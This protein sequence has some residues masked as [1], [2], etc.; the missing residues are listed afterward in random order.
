MRVLVVAP[1]SDFSVA[2]VERGYTKAL[3]ALGCDVATYNLNDRLVYFANC[4]F[5]GRNLEGSEIVL[6]AAWG[7]HGKLYEWWPDLLIVIS[8]FY[9][10]PFT[11]ELLKTRP[12]RTVIVFTESPYEDD[13]QLNLVSEAD[14]DIVILNDPTNRDRFDA[15]HDDVHYFPHAYDPDIHH[16][17]TTPRTTDFSFVGTGYPSRI[18]FLE[19]INFDGLHVELAGHWRNLSSSLNSLLIHDPEECYPNEDAAEIYRRTKVSANLYR[20]NDPIEANGPDLMSGWACGP[21]EIE[22]AACETYFLRE[23]RGEGDD[24]FPMLPTFTEPAEFTE[25]LRWALAHD[26]AR[27]KAAKEAREAIADRTFDAN[28]RRLLNMADD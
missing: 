17:G 19:Q 9:V 27:D 6:H 13:R 24:L 22:L 12:H 18:R 26:H 28:A 2:D 15:I 11:W 14:P 1:G 8:G 7:L 10:L 21:R 23:P 4:V 20:G 5:N 16:P 3:T 25:Q